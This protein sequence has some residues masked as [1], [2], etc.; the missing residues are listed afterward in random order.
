[1][2]GVV[3]RPRILDRTPKGGRDMHVNVDAEEMTRFK[4]GFL[5]GVAASV[6][7][8]FGIAVFVAARLSPFGGPFPVVIARN[9]LH[10]RGASADVFGVLLHLLYGGV[11]G[12]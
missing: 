8:G 6:V 10:F 2:D 5:A 11:A 9:I 1:M 4:R 3:S 7:M 12:G